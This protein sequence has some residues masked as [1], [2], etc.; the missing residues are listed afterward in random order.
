[1]GYD[2]IHLSQQLKTARILIVDDQQENLEVSKYY[3]NRAGY[4]NIQVTDSPHDAIGLLR[5][6]VFDIIL[7]DLMMPDIDGFDVLKYSS[8]FRSNSGPIIVVTARSDDDTKIKA[9]KIIGVRDYISKPFL[10]SELLLRV[11]NL[12]EMHIAQCQLK[13]QNQ[14]MDKILK[15]QNKDLIDRNIQ[16]REHNVDMLERIGLAAEFRDNETGFHVT[17]MSKYSQALGVKIGLKSFDTDLL[18]MTAPMHDVGKIGV[19]DSVLLK[20]GKLT[21]DEWCIMQKHPAI[22][23]RILSNRPS[24]IRSARRHSILI[25][26]GRLIALTHHERWDGKGYPR[27]IAGSDIPL[28]SRIVTIADV[29]DALTSDRPYKS[30]WTIDKTIT[31]L[32][33]GRET[34]FDPNILDAFIDDLPTI[35]AIKQ[36]YQDGEELWL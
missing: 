27:K 25:E 17:R 18:L 14:N 32:K 28:F 21:P 34:Q 19:P 11:R 3:L 4:E 36:L 22:G 5:N 35:L 31:T 1:M 13:V 6:K 12:L 23:A 33:E 24:R 10:E 20:P 9:L 30:A 16:L 8:S 26:T 29:F 15:E 2:M 7:L